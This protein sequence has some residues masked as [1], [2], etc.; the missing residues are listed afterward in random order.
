MVCI[1]GRGV[2]QG[3]RVSIHSGGIGSQGHT[4]AAGEQLPDPDAQ[5][6]RNDRSGTKQRYSLLWCAH[7]HHQQSHHTNQ[8]LKRQLVLHKFS[9][10]SCI[11]CPSQPTCAVRFALHTSTLLRACVYTYSLIW[12]CLALKQTTNNTTT[13]T[14]QNA[15]AQPWQAVATTTPSVHR[16][17]SMQASYSR[18]PQQQQL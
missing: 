16:L 13:T 6:L 18:R 1:D 5:T 9:D 7:K 4:S 15:V 17:F 2:I 3:R 8:L 12:V 14:Q 11:C 10:L